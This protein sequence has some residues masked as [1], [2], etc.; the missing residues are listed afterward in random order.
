MRLTT[1][2]HS[3]DALTYHSVNSA[4]SELLAEYMAVVNVWL[5]T[6]LDGSLAQIN[7]LIGSYWNRHPLLSLMPLRPLTAFNS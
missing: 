3:T 1:L 6:S 7:D 2:N 4:F 5:A